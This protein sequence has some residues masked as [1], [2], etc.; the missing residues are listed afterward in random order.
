[1]I[2]R[3]VKILLTALLAMLLSASTTAQI[4][5]VKGLYVNFINSWLGNTV[6]ED[7]ILDYCQVNGFNYITLYDLNLL[8]WSATQKTQL[9]AFITKAKNV[10]G[11]Q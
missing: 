4:A 8:N 3:N 5:N 6:E 7:K 9:A 2:Q 11:V 1:M 10:Y